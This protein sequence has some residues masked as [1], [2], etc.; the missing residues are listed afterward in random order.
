MTQPEA[1]MEPN[2]GNSATTGRVLVV[3][4]WTTDAAVVVAACRR[5]REQD[6]T[7]LGLVVPA[8]LHGLDWVGD[9]SASIPC[10]QRQ[11]GSIGRLAAAAG[12]HF[13]AAAVGDPDPLA[14]I[15][16]ALADWP[17]DELLLCTRARR[18]AVPHPFA[19][20]HRARRLTGLA[21]S[22]LELPV[23]PR[24][25]V[26]SWALRLG[27]GQCVLDQPQAA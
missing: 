18:V 12:L 24:S 10:A 20:E 13:D 14:A 25:A 27:R 17:A 15:S 8:R 6:G 16:D 2:R 22:R 11:L 23:A 9:P 5:R 7:A 4:D 21:V 3:A 26:R 19:L 1:T